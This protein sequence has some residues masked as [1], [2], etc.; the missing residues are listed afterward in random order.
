MTYCQFVDTVEEKVKEEVREELMVS[1]YTA[2]K[3]NGVMRTG[4]MIR[5]E[6]IN[7]SPAIYLEEY[8]E[9]FRDGDS[10]EEIIGDILRV[11]DRVKFR[12]S[13]NYKYP[14]EYEE[15]RGRIVF[16][17]INRNANREFLKDVPY[18]PYLDLA[19]VFYVLVEVNIYGMA[20]MPVENGHMENWRI[21]LKE[22][23][24]H[25]K[26]NTPRLLPADFQ[27]VQA[28]LEEMIYKR[29][30]EKKDFMYVLS[31]RIRSF[32]A[33]AMLYKDQLANIGRLLRENY[34]VIPSSVHEVLIIAESEVPCKELLDDMIQEINEEYIEQ[35]E[36]LSGHAYYYDC[37]TGKIK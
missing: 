24:D 7:I 29:E 35:E 5:D 36:I 2:R 1:V 25:A 26:E 28:A 19:I 31:N 23:Y 20:S 16:R 27:T 13:W 32:G 15:V 33:A 11:Y 12:E 37:I 30:S 34:Y 17:L 21:T 6:E 9:K 22:L 10:M 3:N 8:Y 14:R 18:V 4:L